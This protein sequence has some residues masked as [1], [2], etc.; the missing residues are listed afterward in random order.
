MQPTAMCPTMLPL[1][2]VLKTAKGNTAPVKQSTV[3][4]L[5]LDNRIYTCTVVFFVFVGRLTFLNALL[6]FPQNAKNKKT[7]SYLPSCL[8]NTRPVKHYLALL[9]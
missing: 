3:A 1:N 6:D 7:Y 8:Q 5:R 9:Y 4:P 2:I